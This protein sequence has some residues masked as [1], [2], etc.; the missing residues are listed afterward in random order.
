MYFEIMLEKL[1]IK[2]FVKKNKILC[3]HYW[4][5]IPAISLNILKK[6]FFNVTFL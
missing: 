5:I 1:Y 2:I 3:M 4:S 6:T